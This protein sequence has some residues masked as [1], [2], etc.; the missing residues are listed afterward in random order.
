[1]QHSAHSNIPLD[2]L[3]GLVVSATGALLLVHTVHNL[4]FLVLLILIFIFSLL[5][6]Y[7]AYN[8]LSSLIRKIFV[9]GGFPGIQAAPCCAQNPV[10][11]ASGAVGYCI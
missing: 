5:S 4:I 8:V 2:V 9:F 6:G 7:N 3:V 1:V 11:P 10:Y